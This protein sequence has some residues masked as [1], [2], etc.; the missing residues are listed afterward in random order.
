MPVIEQHEQ[1]IQTEKTVK[2]AAVQYDYYDICNNLQCDHSFAWRASTPI[3]ITLSKPVE[4]FPIPVHSSPSKNGN[5]LT[6]S[7]D[8]RSSISVQDMSVICEYKLSVRYRWS[9]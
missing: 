9:K 3:P 4:L 7:Y 6:D 1:G 2:D 5:P 8:D